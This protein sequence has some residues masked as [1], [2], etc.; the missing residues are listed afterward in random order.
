MVATHV[1]LLFFFPGEKGMGGHEGESARER[2]VMSH[3]GGAS[4]NKTIMHIYTVR[5]GCGLLQRRLIA[6]SYRLWAQSLLGVPSSLSGGDSCARM[7][8]KL[9]TGGGMRAGNGVIIGWRGG[10]GNYDNEIS[11]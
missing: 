2:G 9:G 5:I 10:R 4:M 8:P 6:C 11:G 7:T 3:D 1:T